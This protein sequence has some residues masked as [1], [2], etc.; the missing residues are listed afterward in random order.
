MDTSHFRISTTFF[1]Y[2]FL[3]D[4]SH[5]PEGNWDTKNVQ[6]YAP[7]SKVCSPS[8]HQILHLIGRFPWEIQYSHVFV[9]HTCYCRNVYAF[10]VVSTV[11]EKRVI[12]FWESVLMNAVRVFQQCKV[13]FLMFWLIFC[14]F[15]FLSCTY[16]YIYIMKNRLASSLQLIYSR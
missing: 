12:Q 7:L 13:C 4:C 6:K 10:Q 5:H 14:L 15:V 2:L 16:I 8:D 3:F 1:W 9:P 11:W